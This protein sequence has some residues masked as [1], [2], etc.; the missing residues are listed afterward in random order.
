MLIKTHKLYLKT[1]QVEVRDHFVNVPSQWETTLQCNVVSHWRS[2]FTKWSL[3]RFWDLGGDFNI[4]ILRPRQNERH[5]A[6]SIFKCILLNEN[7]WIS[8]KVSLNFVPLAQINN[9][10]TLVQ[11][12]AWR[13]PGTKPWWLV[14]WC[15]YMHHLASI[16]L[17]ATDLDA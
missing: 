13:R 4:N 9:I 15:V 3:R 14:Y 12:M 2:T 7:K 17:Q 8:L 5:F 10:P 11:V 6:D 16:S 1:W